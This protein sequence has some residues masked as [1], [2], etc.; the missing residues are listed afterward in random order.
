MGVTQFNLTIVRCT[1]ECQLGQNLDCFSQ[2]SMYYVF[3]NQHVKSWIYASEGFICFKFL[4][5]DTVFFI[6]HLNFL[7]WKISDTNMERKVKWILIYLSSK[8]KL[9]RH[10]Y[11][12]FIVFTLQEYVKYKFKKISN[13]LQKSTQTI[14]I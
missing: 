13:K 7:I 8:F 1:G 11:D 2:D 6:L 5:D 3:I 10:Y 12:C 4:G 9:S 14:R